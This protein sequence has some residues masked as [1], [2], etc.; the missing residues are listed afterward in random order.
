MFYEIILR[1]IAITPYHPEIPFHK[2]ACW[3]INMLFNFIV[4]LWV[5][6]YHNNTAKGTF[7]IYDITKKSRAFLRCY[8]AGKKAR[9]SN[10]VKNVALRVVLISLSL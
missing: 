4:L 6:L 9:F 5:Q 2:F 10:A 1:F 3:V 8:A 7:F